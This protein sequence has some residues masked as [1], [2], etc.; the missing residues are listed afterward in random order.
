M[1]TTSP[2]RTCARHERRAGVGDARVDLDAAVHRAGMHHDLTGADA[3]RGDPVERRVLAQAGTI[4]GARAPS[5]RAASAGRRRRRR[6]RSRRSS[7][8]TSQPIASIPRGSSVG[9]PTSVVRA[10]TSASAS[11]SDRATREWRTSPTIATWTPVEPA[12]R[13]ADR[14]QVEQ[15][16]RRVLVLAVAGVDDVRPVASRD[17]LRRAD[18]RMPDH[19]HVGVVRRE[20]ERG[21]LAA[22]RPCRP[23]S[24]MTR[25]AIVSAESRFAAR[26]KLESVRV[27]DS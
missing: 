2:D 23:T 12:E 22:T 13:L 9:G 26:S 14:E 16:L 4:R 24:P 27:D 8:E 18:V 1:R 15:R 5:A 17:E 11:T 19:D 6:R 25:S 10:P 7:V 20:R 21:V 3:L